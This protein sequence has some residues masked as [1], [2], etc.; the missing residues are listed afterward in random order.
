M[1]THAKGSFE[2]KLT[3]QEGRE[4]AGAPAVGHMSIDKQFHGDLEGFSVGEMLTAGSE[5]GAA[6]YVALEK[7]SGTLH[8]RSG[9]FVLI[10]NG[11]MQ[12]ETQQLTITVMP[13]SGTD[14][15]AGLA[16]KLMINIIDKKH[17]YDFE[18]TLAGNA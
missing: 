10:H 14:Q 1:S 6:A 13:G 7:V 9:T 5:T 18:Y 2:V 4:S 11:L 3:Q 12:P 17:F 8:G 15:L 16:G